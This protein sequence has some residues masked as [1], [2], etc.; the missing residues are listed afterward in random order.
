M[1]TSIDEAMIAFSGRL[2]FKQYMPLK[3]TKWGIKVWIQAYPN[4]DYVNEF[5]HVY[6][7]NYFT[8]VP[9]FQKLLDNQT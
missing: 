7:D 5:H 4:N 6:C 8:S 3:P 9:L 2:G 1:E